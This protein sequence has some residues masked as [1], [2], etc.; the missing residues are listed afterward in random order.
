MWSD[1]NISLL[2]AIVPIN[3]DQVK[4]LVNKLHSEG[5]FDGFLNNDFLWENNGSIETPKH[6][7]EEVIFNI[8]M[9]VGKIKKERPYKTINGIKR[10][11]RSFGITMI[12]PFTFKEEIPLENWG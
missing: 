6:S 3:G 5:E 2:E 12:R 4:E 1:K 7:E 11:L 8:C 9:A 10:V